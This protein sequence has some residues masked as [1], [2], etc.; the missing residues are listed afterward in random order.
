MLMAYLKIFILFIFCFAIIIIGVWAFRPSVKKQM[1]TYAK[2]P[3]KEDGNE[4]DE[5]NLKNE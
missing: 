4:S 5:K 2:I 3:L 1:E